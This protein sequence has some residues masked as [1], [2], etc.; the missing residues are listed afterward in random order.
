[1]FCKIVTLAFPDFS[2]P[3]ILDTDASDVGIGKV[4]SQ[5]NKSNVEQPVAYYSRS[6]SKAEQKY[7]G[8]RKEMLAL[9]DSLRH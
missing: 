7:A 6:L 2:K 1:M 9:V 4:L 3:F 8:T 5:L